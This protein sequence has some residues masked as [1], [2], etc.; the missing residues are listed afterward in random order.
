LEVTVV[1]ISLSVVAFQELIHPMV[2]KSRLEFLPLM[3]NSVFCASFNCCWIVSLYWQQLQ[4]PASD[5]SKVGSG[6]EDSRVG[7]GEDSHIGS[8]EE[9]MGVE[10]ESSLSGV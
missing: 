3:L 8:R 5:Y 9:W 4:D 6:E 7:M 10:E 2:M 1:L